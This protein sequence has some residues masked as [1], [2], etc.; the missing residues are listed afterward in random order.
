MSAGVTAA[1][2]PA[3]GSV[4]FQIVDAKPESKLFMKVAHVASLRRK[5]SLSVRFPSKSGRMVLTTH[6]PSFDASDGASVRIKRGWGNVHVC[7]RLCMC[8]WWCALVVSV[9]C[10]DCV[11]LVDGCVVQ[12]VYCCLTVVS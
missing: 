7:V 5:R 4:V 12:V 11:V 3:A 9:C 1:A 6:T 2:G 10:V 8:V